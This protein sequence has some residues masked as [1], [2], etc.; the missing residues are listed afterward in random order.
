MAPDCLFE[1]GPGCD[2]NKTPAGASTRNDVRTVKGSVPYGGEGIY[3]CEKP[4]TVAITY[5]DGPYIYTD[6]VLNKFKAAGFKAT[7]FITGNN[8]GK[9]AID[10]KWSAVIKR[11]VA[12]GHQVASHTWSHQ[13]LSQIT[14][15]QV[16][17]QMVKNEMAIRNIIG[18]YPTYMRPPYS[19]CTAAVCQKV[20]KALGYVVSYFDLDTD[21]YNQLTKEKIEVAKNNFRNAVN[22]ANPASDSKLSIA[23]DIHELT[24]LNL[25]VTMIETLQARGFKGVTMGE[26][27]NDPAANWYRDST[28][29][30]PASTTA[31]TAPTATPT[32]VV[33]TDGS[34][35]TQGKNQICLGSS[36]GNC[37]SQYG[38]C[39]TSTDHCGTS[40]QTLFGNC[41]TNANAPTSTKATSAAP[42]PTTALKTSVDGTCGASTGF[43]CVGFVHEGVK[44]ECCSQYG[45]CGAS[46]DHC[47]TGCNPLAGTCR[48]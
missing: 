20:L 11:M 31:T 7:F 13:D 3:A 34:C 27:M 6:E 39:G 22:G 2:A 9:G 8:I 23:H 19:S 1:Y 21:D 12:E 40:C 45:Y 18:K 26:C 14:E 35:G 4:G 48:N 16:Y 30:P 32:G 25:T 46:T 36:F 15:A 37:C 38:W 24:A 41:G 10:E 33:S 29:A 47:G 5:D 42:Q 44:S 28:A 17:D 43:T